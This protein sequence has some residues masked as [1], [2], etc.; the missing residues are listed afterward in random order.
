MECSAVDL[1]SVETCLYFDAYAEGGEDV[2]LPCGILD[3]DSGGT[4]VV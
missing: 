2:T 4:G 1:G 3:L